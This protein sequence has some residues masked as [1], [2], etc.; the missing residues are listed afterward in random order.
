MTPLA[1]WLGR[2][3]GRGMAATKPLCSLVEFSCGRVDCGSACIDLRRCDRALQCV[4][5]VARVRRAGGDS[6]LRSVAAIQRGAD[7]LRGTGLDFY[8][9]FTGPAFGA[10]DR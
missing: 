5:T 1:V 4:H 8:G 6:G 2:S 3:A 7:F 9:L 10:V